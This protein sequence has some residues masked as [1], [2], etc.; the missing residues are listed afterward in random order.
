MLPE[1]IVKLAM[2]LTR[3]PVQNVRKD[4]V[5]LE[6]CVFLAERTC[7]I[8][9]NALKAEIHVISVTQLLLK[10]TQMENVHNARL[11]EDGCLT[12]NLMAVQNVNVVMTNLLTL[13]KEENV[14]H[15]NNSSQAVECVNKLT[16]HHKEQ[17]ASVSATTHK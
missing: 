8:V 11:E 6:D 9:S 7:I 17:Q 5:L 14:R 3:R 10:W 1:F 13:E 2:E 15:V 16:T 12:P 4:L